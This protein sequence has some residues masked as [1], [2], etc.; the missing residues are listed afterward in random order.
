MVLQGA[1]T[2]EIG[3]IFHFVINLIYYLY[4]SNSSSDIILLCFGKE[5]CHDEQ[6]ARNYR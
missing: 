6:G 2:A 4:L 3:K 5:V 1:D